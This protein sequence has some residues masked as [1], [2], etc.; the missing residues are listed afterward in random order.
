[1]M[2]VDMTT[3]RS[4][5]R[6]FASATICAIVLATPCT[7]AETPHRNA[8]VNDLSAQGVEASSAS[9]ISD[10]VRN[11]LVKT[12][13]FTVVER[14]QMESI[15]KEQG[16]QQ[17]G[18]CTNEA[19]MVEMGQILGVDCMITGTIGRI[20]HTFTMGLRLIDVQSGK[21]TASANVDCKCDIDELLSNS[22]TEIVH[23]LLGEYNKRLSSGSAAVSQTG[24]SAGQA[25]A[26]AHKKSRLGLKIG[27]GVGGLAAL[28][29]GIAFDQTVKDRANKA[30]AA[31]RASANA[32]T[33]GEFDAAAA[34][35]KT[36]RDAAAQYS[37]Y[38]N[39]GYI[40]AGLCAAGLVL[41]FTF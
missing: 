12:G 25:G 9:I 35:Y 8:A 16:F 14:G 22:T 39:I 3:F 41:T 28:G 21:I 11:E 17:S 10:R 1:M 7:G 6:F 18:V 30:D 13:A 15:L 38:R 34:D 2:N 40:A 23:Q 20:G 26:K 36:N 5:L 19:C 24:A 33:S 27:L 31:K 37:L 29:A 4:P 32:I